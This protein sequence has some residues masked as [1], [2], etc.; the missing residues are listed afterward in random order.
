MRKQVLINE[1]INPKHV[2]DYIQK[3]A[4]EIKFN[5]YI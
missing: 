4:S 1:V 3:L 5:L 2:S